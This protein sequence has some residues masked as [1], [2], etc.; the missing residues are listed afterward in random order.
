MTGSGSSCFGIFK[1]EED[2]TSQKAYDDLKKVDD[3]FIWYGNKKEFGYNR[4]LL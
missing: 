1:N 2:F 4:I 3:F